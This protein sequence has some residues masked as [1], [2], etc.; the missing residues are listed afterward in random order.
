MSNWSKLSISKLKDWQSSKEQIQTESKKGWWNKK[1]KKS[2]E[3]PVVKKNRRGSKWVEQGPQLE[4]FEE[5]SIGRQ[6]SNILTGREAETVNWAIADWS[7]QPD[8]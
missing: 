2:V 4:T 3:G 5:I 7:K 1:N 6:H 8:N